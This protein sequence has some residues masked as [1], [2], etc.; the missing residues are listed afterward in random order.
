MAKDAAMAKD[1]AA[2]AAA[3]FRCLCFSLSLQSVKV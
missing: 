2:A 3:I 1:D